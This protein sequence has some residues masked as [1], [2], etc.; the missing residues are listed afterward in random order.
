MKQTIEPIEFT[1]TDSGLVALARGMLDAGARLLTGRANYMRSLL[2]IAQTELGGAPRLT[3]ARKLGEL[4]DAERESQLAALKTAHGRCWAVI[5]PVLA[6]TLA[7]E[8]RTELHRRATYVRTALATL[9][10]IVHA[11][12]SLLDISARTA[13]KEALRALVTE[14]RGEG[15]RAHR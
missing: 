12:I 14:R 8:S 6:E 1:T 10:A 15:A 5:E 3:Q 4:T 7:G 13:T 9:R 11:R 2:A